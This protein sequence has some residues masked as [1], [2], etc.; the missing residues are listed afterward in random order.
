[1]TWQWE[2]LRAK[3]GIF[4]YHAAYLSKRHWSAFEEQSEVNE[5]DQ[6]EELLFINGAV[7]QPLRIL[8]PKDSA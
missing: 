2:R 7:V 6:R 5:M 1:M 8:F 3:F 4:C